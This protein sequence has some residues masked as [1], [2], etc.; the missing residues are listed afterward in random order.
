MIAVSIAITFG[1]RIRGKAALFIT[2]LCQIAD[3]KN[4]KYLQVAMT[5]KGI[6]PHVLGKKCGIQGIGGVGW[7]V[8]KNLPCKLN[9]RFTIYNIQFFTEEHNL[10]RATKIEKKYYSRNFQDDVYN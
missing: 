7:F 5:P 8:T 4:I 6:M 10:E 3:D 1:T 2:A 9:R